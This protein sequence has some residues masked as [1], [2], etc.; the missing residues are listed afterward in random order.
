MRP[1]RHSSVTTRG[2]VDKAPSD[3][4]SPEV[5]ALLDHLA[6]EL[7]AEYM[8]LL[9]PQYGTPGEPDLPCEREFGK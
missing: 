4:L 8:R 1:V 6:E 7:A 3:L 5:L 2:G 9:A